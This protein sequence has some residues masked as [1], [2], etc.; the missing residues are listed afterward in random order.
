MTN[1]PTILPFL[2]VL[3]ALVG[4]LAAQ[5]ASPA[6]L[7]ALIIDGQNNHKW[8]QTTPLLRQTLE[9]SGRFT[10]DVVTSPGR[11]EE[12]ATFAPEFAK[13]DVVVSNYNGR[14]WPKATRESFAKYVREGGG[15]VSVHAADNAF[16]N[17][18]DYN[19][20]IGV[21]GWGRRNERSGP[22]VRWRDGK[23][24][25]DTGPGR[26]GGHGRRHEFALDVRDATH[27]ITK[28][29]PA[30][31]M[32]CADELYDKLRGPA[33]NL[34][35]LAT[36]FSAK[37]TGGSGEHEPL[38]MAID[39]GKGRCFHTALGHD[40]T[41]MKCVAF[42][43]TLVRGAEWA[44]TGE[45]TTAIPGDFPGAD[46]AVAK[47]PAP[48]P[49]AGRYQIPPSDV[50]LPGTGTIRRYP[51]F[52]NLWQRKRS[53]WAERAESD[54]GAVVFFGDSITQGW[55]DALGGSFPDRKVANRGIS[56][57]T[58][59]GMLLRLDG[60]VLALDPRAVVM[61][62]GTNDLE[63]GDS[64][65]SVANNVSE[66]V[67]RIVERDDDVP[68]VLCK[69]FPSAAKMRRPA[70]KIR[71]INAK[72]VAAVADRPQVTVV[73]TW[74]IFA[75]ANGN[76][77]KAEFPDL[78]HPNE[79][80]YRKWAGAL[81]PVLARLLGSTVDAVLDRAE[82][83]LRD[84]YDRGAYRARRFRAD[85]LPDG[86]AYVV[87]ERQAD[88]KTVRQKVDPESGARSR[89]TGAERQQ[90]DHAPRR[91]PDGART[92]EF[93][94]GDL[95]VRGDG[96]ARVRITSNAEREGVRNGQP[97]WSP[98]G[99]QVLFV[100][101]DSSRVRMRNTLVPN[102]PSYPG[103]RQV[104][105]ARV[106]ETI[107]S[108]RVG[109]A[110]ADGT[111]TKW[112]DVPQPKE[113]FYL[114]QVEWAGNS[115]EI[116]VEWLSRFR[117]RREFLL[118]NWRSGAVT[119]IY[120]ES[121]PAW[122]VASYGVN[123]GL[124]WVRDGAAFVVISE[125]DGWRHAWLHARDGTELALLTPGEFDII[126]RAHV[127][128]SGGWF[129]YY[130][131]PE[132]AAQKYLY[133]VP[134]DGSA[135][136]ERITPAGQPGTHD[137]DI[138]P[139]GLWALHTWSTF[140]TPPVTELVELPSHR[141]VR[142]LEDN[143]ALR[144][145]VAAL[146]PRPTEFVAI[147]IGDGVTVD[148]WLMKPPDFDPSKKYPVLVYVYSEPHAQ[149]VLDAWGKVHSEYHR[150]VSD[151]GYLVLSI[152]SRG[153]P[154]PK[155]AAWRRA[156]FGSLGPISTAEQAAAL[157]ALARERAYIDLDRVGIWG[158]SGGGS[159]T[160]NAMFRRPDLY[161]VGIAVA[162]KPQPQL[163]N[164]W[165][166][167]IYMRTRKENAEGYKRSAPIHFAEGLEG[168]LL[169]V[170]GTGELNTHVQIM[171]GL[172]DRLIEL[173]KRFDYFTYPN[174]RH[175]LREGKG[176]AVHLRMLMV[177]YLLEHLEAGGR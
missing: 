64:A 77:K 13:Y 135:K 54:R 21:G 151:L 80:G 18:R 65:E 73:D 153:T 127:D 36:A 149:T 12:I 168:D 71:E 41:A 172:V 51:W 98:D 81:R 177:R 169:I 97:V 159:N 165:F 62:M 103:A 85:W 17:W 45:V 88:G 25:R 30:R 120:E 147:D 128:R 116:L 155:G 139:N 121:D 61:L 84:I 91:S 146:D 142:V 114:G 8:Q 74:S 69:V 158:W 166:Q 7:T 40:E 57:D 144:E 89:L 5:D 2:F 83:R 106:G 107:A 11:K 60:D 140:D 108:R 150:L 133:R 160:L 154:A 130:A 32:H 26:G 94:R 167:E 156:V 87:R 68:I 22:Y 171:E 99:N 58:T 52:Q 123:K 6:K 76:A 119:T 42:Q 23:I 164:A 90:L 100:E 72:L 29:L 113:G 3:T 38:L 157:E 111:F 27:P 47:D 70:D 16:P 118:V 117:D 35:V 96:G 44:A 48:Q 105:F 31:F 131:S 50:G 137:Y 163:Y 115:D 138:A 104:R 136:P 49:Q 129:Y 53:G 174:R 109:V 148:A 56:G 9:N 143:A 82:Q 126:E 67:R 161:D 59:R 10:V 46:A 37:E 20:M 92:V 34:T 43:V 162:A 173:G 134:L 1:R 141:V 75:D 170:H 125:R 102:D 176:T 39:F 110:A 4:S 101:T 112:L 19:L 152:D 14:L 78:L 132:N 145:R 93:V 122:V 79:R 24:V 55:G 63:E 95:E 124:E 15:F 66:I 86:S 33:E 28:G 175:G